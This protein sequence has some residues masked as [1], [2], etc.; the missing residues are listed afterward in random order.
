VLYRSPATRFVGGFVGAMNTIRAELRT[1]ADGPVAVVGGA[2][3]PVESA[4]ATTSGSGILGVRPENVLLGA[5][6]DGAG[7]TIVRAIPRG[8]F[9]EVV[10]QLI[11]DTEE[12]VELRSY[13]DDRSP[14]AALGAGDQ[15]GVR[16]HS[17]LPYD[18]NGVLR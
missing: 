2:G 8:H 18:E 14:V 10:V 12:P 17:V 4:S 9:T 13:I 7:A 15:V 3:L 11:A 5:K 1:G 16:L 6:S